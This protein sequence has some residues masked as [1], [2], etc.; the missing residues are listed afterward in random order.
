MPKVTKKDV[1]KPRKVAVRKEIYAGISFPI[2]RIQNRMR[3]LNANKTVTGNS[4]VFLAAELEYIAAEICDLAGNMCM[5]A[6]QKT[7]SQKH[8]FEAI[9]GDA[10]LSKIFAAGIIH[11]G[12]VKKTVTDFRYKS[13][14][15]IAENEKKAEKKAAKEQLATMGA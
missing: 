4:A 2:S 3:K 12:G 14:R 10:E 15:Q 8:L 11:E 9:N 5:D 6:G 7:L 13:V 1:S